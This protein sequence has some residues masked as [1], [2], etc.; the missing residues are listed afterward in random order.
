M[1]RKMGFWT[2]SFLGAAS[3][4]LAGMSYAEEVPY[5]EGQQPPAAACGYKWE[6]KTKAGCAKKYVQ[7][8]LCAPASTRELV[9]PADY[10]PREAKIMV[11]PEMKK[12]VCQ[13]GEY[14]TDTVKIECSDDP[15]VYEFVPP[16]YEMV[17]KEV[18]VEE[19]STELCVTPA[20]YKTE[21]CK[22]AVAPARKVLR[23]ICASEAAALKAKGAKVIE[24]VENDGCSPCKQTTVCFVE[25]EVPCKWTSIEKK[26]Q[27]KPEA[28]TEIKIPAKVCKVKVKKLVK[29]PEI[30]KVKCDIPVQ[31]ICVKKQVKK[32]E[33]KSE[34]IPAEYATI[35]QEVQVKPEE[36]RQVEVPAQYKTVTVDCGQEEKVWV[37]VKSGDVCGTCSVCEKKAPCNACEKK[38]PCAP[39]AAKLPSMPGFV[40]A[41]R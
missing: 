8:I 15:Y 41:A 10:A 30:K 5:V 23:K 11:A 39:C 12:V 2:A 29:G 31:T 19:E 3:F 4:V 27:V 28:V 9:I 32:P 1:S 26:V 14:T 13:P 33:V 38:A 37:K 7:R 24:K 20:E 17:E 21:T 22:I 6:L 36:V 16:V 18:V 40:P 35:C 34:T 25:E